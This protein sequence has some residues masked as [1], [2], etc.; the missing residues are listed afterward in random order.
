MTT[1]TLKKFLAFEHRQVFAHGMSVDSPEGLHM[2][3]S[4]KTLYWVAVKGA[5]DDWALYCGLEDNI[6]QLRMYGDK[7][8]DDRNITRVIS[9]SPAVLKLYRSR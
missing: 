5:I 2:T 1:I 4:G 9:V 3:G 8:H 6:E 7:V